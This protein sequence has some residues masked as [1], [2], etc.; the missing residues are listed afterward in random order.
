MVP[1]VETRKPPIEVGNLKSSWF[2]KIQTFLK[3][4]HTHFVPTLSTKGRVW[5]RVYLGFQGFRDQFAH[6][7]AL[8]VGFSLLHPKNTRN[9]TSWGLS[10][11]KFNLQLLKNPEKGEKIGEN[12]PFDQTFIHPR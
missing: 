8:E 1:R 9:D 7:G 10:W 6:L 11:P 4:I 12:A 5:G 2:A 3:P